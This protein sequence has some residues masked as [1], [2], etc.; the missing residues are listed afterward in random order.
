MKATKVAF[1][2]V[3]VAQRKDVLNKDHMQ[4]T[5]DTCHDKFP[6]Q[7]AVDS[8]RCSQRW[9]CKTCNAKTTN[10][11]NYELHLKKGCQLRTCKKCFHVTYNEERFKAHKKN[12]R[13]VLCDI[14]RIPC[15]NL[16]DRVQHRRK[17]HKTYK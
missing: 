7:F 1:S 3:N 8:H 6:S 4:F 13:T 9:V 16:Y 14:C 2:Q 10:K 17:I 12:C 15:K 11:Y 5:C